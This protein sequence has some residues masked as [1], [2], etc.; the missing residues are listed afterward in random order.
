MIKLT[1]KGFVSDPETTDPSA[2]L[3]V[4]YS[5]LTEEERITI[6]AVI[7]RARALTPDE[8]AAFSRLLSLAGGHALSLEIFSTLSHL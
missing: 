6:R 1:Q 4:A 5:L 8:Q 7:A 2:A 3:R